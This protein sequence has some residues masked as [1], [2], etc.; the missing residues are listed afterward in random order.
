MVLVEGVA[1]LSEGWGTTRFFKLIGVSWLDGCRLV[2]KLNSLCLP[3]VFFR[4]AWFKFF[5]SKF[6][7]E[8]CFGVEVYVSDSRAYRSVIVAVYLFSAICKQYPGE[9]KFRECVFD[10]LV[11]TDILRKALEVGRLFT[12]IVAGWKKGLAAF[13]KCREFYLFYC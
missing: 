5:F 1:I 13:L 12:L 6:F 3:G 9:F 11:G 2:K 10:W 4:E 8:E 7:G